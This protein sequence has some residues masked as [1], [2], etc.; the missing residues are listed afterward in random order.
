MTESTKSPRKR[1]LQSGFG[2]P[3]VILSLF[4]LTTMLF[5]TSSRS[6]LS[7]RENSGF[8]QRNERETLKKVILTSI[9]C[10]E[11]N[12]ATYNPDQLFIE[13]YET[14]CPSTSLNQ[15]GPFLKLSRLTFAGPKPLFGATHP[16]D[17]IYRA[18]DFLIRASC[19]ASENGYV[20]QA[21]PAQDQNRDKLTGKPIQWNSNQ[22]LLI[23]KP[24]RIKLC[25]KRPPPQL[26]CSGKSCYEQNP[27]VFSVYT[28]E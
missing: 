25:S 22:A 1:S 4:A 18:G 28:L 20:I 23:G 10:F 8:R 13:P 16:G 3:L 5:L 12:R 6:V 19:S 15:V 26:K 11:T 9:N 17:G 24:V 21:I 7:L 2:I 14:R 27:K